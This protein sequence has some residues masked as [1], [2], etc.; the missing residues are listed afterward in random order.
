[1][2]ETACQGVGT[3]IICGGM[4]GG[5]ETLQI[6]VLCLDL[7]PN[8][9]GFSAGHRPDSVCRP[10]LAPFGITEKEARAIEIETLTV[11]DPRENDVEDLVELGGT[12][13]GPGYGE[14]K[15][16]FLEK[17]TI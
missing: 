2:R 17:L 11:S 4:I 10:Q 1:M 12:K 3:R 9:F 15:T 8:P 7:V 16:H 13:H 5:Q 14:L 6:H